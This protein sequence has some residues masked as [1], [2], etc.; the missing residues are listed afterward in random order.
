M[1]Q[2]M[3]LIDAEAD[4]DVFK[5]AASRNGVLILKLLHDAGGLNVN[6]IAERL[7]QPQSSV[8]NNV[9]ALEKAGL[10]RTEMISARKGSQKVCHA[11][12]DEMVVSF[13]KPTG[14]LPS[15]VIEVAMPLGL[16]TK[17][18][19]VGPCGICSPTGIIGL[20]DVPETFLDPERM[21][22]SLLWFTS[23][24]VEYQ[25]PNNALLKGLDVGRIEF[26]LE[27]SSEVPGTHTDW[28]S[29]ICVSVNGVELGVWTSP[30]DFGDRRGVYTPDWWKLAGSQYGLL[31]TWQVT[32]EGAFV[33]GRQISDVVL[34]DLQLS[35]HR[36]VRLR[37]EVKPQAR[38]PGGINI[39]GRG[40][41]NYDQDLILRLH[42]K[43]KV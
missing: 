34:R 9:Q 15:D 40:F 11:I 28:P 39:F 38:H 36:S 24:F 41:G 6:Q 1:S 19:V 29:D 20:L 21:K 37:I 16:Y 5:V 33:D 4:F 7:G 17:A 14:S 26:A 43:S 27:V 35:E 13:H 25:F 31:K 3:L 22:A 32:D 18:A 30:G 10:I 12:Y 2:N 42:T 23:G 8:S